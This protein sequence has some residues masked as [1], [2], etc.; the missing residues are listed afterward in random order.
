MARGFQAYVTRFP[1]VQFCIYGHNHRLDASEP[2]EDGVKYYGCPEIAD[3]IY[4]LFTVN[5]KGYEGEKERFKEERNSL[6]NSVGKGPIPI[7]TACLWSLWQ[8][9]PRRELRLRGHI[10]I[11]ER[12][13]LNIKP[14]MSRAHKSISFYYELCTHDL[15]LMSIFTNKYLTLKDATSLAFGL[16]FQIF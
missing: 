5:E 13:T 16:K 14:G 10:F 2:F 1:Q 7:F 11:G 6:A 3:R 4:L 8:P 12:I 9:Y 15:A